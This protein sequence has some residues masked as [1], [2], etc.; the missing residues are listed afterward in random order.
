VWIKISG[1]SS[2]IIATPV[3]ATTVLNNLVQG[4]YQFQLTITDNNGAIGKDIVQVTVNATVSVN[5]MPIVH[6]GADV[7]IVL[8]VNSVALTGAASDPDGS[9][10]FFS[11]KVIAGPRGYLLSFPN[12]PQTSIDNLFQGVYQIELSVTDNMGAIAKDTMYITVSSPRL[13]NNNSNV[14]TVYPNPVQTITSLSITTTNVNTKLSIS[15]TDN[16]GR[17]VRYQELVTVSN[18]TLIKL[19]MSNLSSGYYIVTLR[20]DDGRRVS[21]KVLKYG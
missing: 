20:F 8:P 7:G 12:S 9:I 13:A 5:Q 3:A 14:A 19:D 11:W 2:G 17:V 1:P 18:F 10:A 4:V 21:M 6:A 15:I 16:S